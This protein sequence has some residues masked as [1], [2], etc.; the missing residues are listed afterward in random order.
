[1]KGKFVTLEGCEGVGKSRQLKMLE[2]YLVSNGIKFYMTREPGGTPIAEQIST[3]KV[4]N[5]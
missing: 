3:T 5:L 2:E 1:M 4:Q